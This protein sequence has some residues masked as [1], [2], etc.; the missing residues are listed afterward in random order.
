MLRTA[1]F[2]S[3]LI[4][5]LLP[6]CFA[7]QTSSVY[8]H[9]TAS[10]FCPDASF[11][12][13]VHFIAISP[14][15]PSAQ[16]LSWADLFTLLTFHHFHL[17][18]RCFVQ[19]TFSVYWYFTFCPDAS[20]S[21]LLQFID[22]PPLQPS[23]QMLRSADLFTSLTF[24]HFHLLPRCFVEQICSLY[25]HFTTLTFSPDA[26]LSRFV[27]FIDISPFPPSAQMLRTADFFS[28]LTFHHYR[29]I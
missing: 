7:Q 27:H 6:R 21:R 18:P 19:Q 11:G 29:L 14:L 5:H 1:D 8:W 15:P 22:I 2:F 12:R 25:W 3:L 28:L 26:S 24:H 17:L 20:H 16:M 13:F 10:T 4:L 9:S 23:A